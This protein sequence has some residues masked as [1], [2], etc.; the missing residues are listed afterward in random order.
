MN[1]VEFTNVALIWVGLIALHFR[2][3]LVNRK[4]ESLRDGD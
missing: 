2:I 4:L 1:W 3:T